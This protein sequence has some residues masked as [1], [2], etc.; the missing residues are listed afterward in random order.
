MTTINL[1]SPVGKIIERNARD[2]ARFNYLQSLEPGYAI[3]FFID[4]LSAKD[5]AKAIDQCIALQRAVDSQ[6][7]AT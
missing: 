3:Q 5:R 4:Y 2:A 1:N 6:S 7:I